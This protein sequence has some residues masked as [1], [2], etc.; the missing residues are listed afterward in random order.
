MK[1]ILLCLAAVAAVGSAQA[2]FVFAVVADG[3]LKVGLEDWPGIS[4]VPN[5]NNKGD[6]LEFLAPGH[7]PL[8]GKLGDDGFLRAPLNDLN[9][10]GAQIHYGVLDKGEVFLLDYHAKGAETA[11]DAKTKV[12]LGVEVFVN[13]DAKGWFITVQK[14]G[15][16]QKNLDLTLGLP[17]A[18]DDEETEAKLGESGRYD[19]KIDQPGRLVVRTVIKTKVEGTFEG[20]SYPEHRAYSTL[21][22]NSIAP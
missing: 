21:V 5:I 1:K 20:K 19:L 16:I 3:A 22:V 17:G 6:K 10:A 14:D 18:K 12:G 7:Q 8:Q 15:K 13:K 9:V 11:A 2:H 4:H